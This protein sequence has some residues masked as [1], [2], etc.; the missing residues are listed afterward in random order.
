MID[1][2]G[3][4]RAIAVLMV[5]GSVWAT[6]VV[7]EIP[8]AWTLPTTREDGTPLKSADITG[9]EL[10]YAVEGGPYGVIPVAGSTTLA[11]TAALALEPRTAPYRITWSVIAIAG[12]KSKPSNLDTTSTLVTAPNQPKNYLACMID[13]AKLKLASYACM[14]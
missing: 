12:V 7:V 10:S 4:R 14:K 8:R 6:P 2:N 3:M 1:G 11:T 5:S 13:N 9:Y